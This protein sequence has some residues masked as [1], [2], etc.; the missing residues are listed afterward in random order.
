MTDAELAERCFEIPAR[1]EGIFHLAVMVSDMDSEVFDLLTEAGPLAE[2]I[3][4]EI[5][6]SVDAVLSRYGPSYDER[7]EAFTQ[8]LMDRP[9]LGWLVVV[10][11]PVKK[12]GGAGFSYSWA[13]YDTRAFYADTYTEALEAGLTWATGTYPS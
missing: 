11:T 6:V 5:G 9:V 3:G 12:A 8:A 1:V 13:V 4:E 10:S 7:L 2:R